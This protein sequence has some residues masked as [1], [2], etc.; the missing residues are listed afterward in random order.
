[1]IALVA[2]G[3]S[4]LVSPGWAAVDSAVQT[5]VFQIGLVALLLA[6]L[7]RSGEGSAVVRR[8]S[9]EREEERAR[10]IQQ[11]DQLRRQIDDT[12]RRLVEIHDQVLRRVGVELHDGPAQLISFA[13][14]RLD[15]L[16]EQDTPGS[17]NASPGDL[18]TIRGALKEALAEV[19]CM[20]SGL[21]LPELSLVQPA[22]VLRLAARNHER[23]TG[24]SVVCEME[25]LPEHLPAAVKSCLYRFAQEALN[26]AYRHAGGRGQAVRARYLRGTLEVEV[27]DAGPGFDP[28]S[29]IGRGRLGLLGMRER[30]TSLGG[31]FEIDSRPGLGTR[32]STRFKLAGT[33]GHG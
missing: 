13:L 2:L 14:L 31:T 26:N 3:R 23:R 29:K 15:G 30:V 19:R 28:D 5:P 24:T 25:G 7:A 32:L 10:L 12:Q 11:I 4:L 17:G 22:D 9:H 21:I 16:Q 27:A 6:A 1:M 33:N 20:A 18:E 8:A